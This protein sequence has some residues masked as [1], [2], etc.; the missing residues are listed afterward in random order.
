VHKNEGYLHTNN[1]TPKK[2]KLK[3][4]KKKKAKK[5]I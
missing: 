4:K 2:V 5:N 3:K 1:K